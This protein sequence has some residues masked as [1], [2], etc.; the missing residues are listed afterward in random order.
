MVDL[1]TMHNRVSIFNQRETSFSTTLR[2]LGKMI[3]NL[4]LKP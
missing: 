2:T 3:Y 4:T 1:I